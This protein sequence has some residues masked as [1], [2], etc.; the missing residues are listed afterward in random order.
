[1]FFVHSLSFR[2][3]ISTFFSFFNLI[4][5]FKNLVT[6]LITF[7]STSGYRYTSAENHYLNRQNSWRNTIFHSLFSSRWFVSVSIDLFLN[8]YTNRRMRIGIS[9]IKQKRN[10]LCAVSLQNVGDY[11][12][13][14]LPIPFPVPSFTYRRS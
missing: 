11:S 5:T 10:I 12:P 8:M 4:F 13:S 9:V 14:Q 3:T 6:S 7:Y 2:N 1:M